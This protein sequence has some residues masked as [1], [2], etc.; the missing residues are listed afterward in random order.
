MNQIL[1]AVYKILN[2]RLK[3]DLSYITFSELDLKMHNRFFTIVVA[4]IS[5]N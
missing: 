5:A 3:I 1:S 2:G 4:N